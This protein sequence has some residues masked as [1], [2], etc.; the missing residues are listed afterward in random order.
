M[1]IFHQLDYT[2]DTP[3]QRITINKL[4][5]ALDHFGN[6]EMVIDFL[7][8][9]NSLC[10]VFDFEPKELVLEAYNYLSRFPRIEKVLFYRGKLAI[11]ALVVSNRTAPEK[12]Q[13]YKRNMTVENKPDEF[14]FS[15]VEI[16]KSEYSDIESGKRKIP[17]SW[18]LDE[19][20]TKSY[21]RMQVL[22][23]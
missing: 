8:G 12:I 22:S 2:S 13:M 9:I 17:K 10:E 6:K 23:I 18:K 5:C 20:M 1:S 3:K 4:D 14:I 15:I 19:Q 16:L 11:V 7:N 21:Q